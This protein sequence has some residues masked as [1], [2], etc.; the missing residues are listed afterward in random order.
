M[1]SG[2][3]A[4]LMNVDERYTNM[5]LLDGLGKLQQL[6]G[7]RSKEKDADGDT[8]SNKSIKKNLLRKDV[9][10]SHRSYDK[11]WLNI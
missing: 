4:I 7:G 5:K 6:Q 3:T 1:A 11:T 10:V 2:G 8:N 9:R